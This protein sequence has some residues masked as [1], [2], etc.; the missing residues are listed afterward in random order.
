MKN[1]NFS[2]LDAM[3]LDEVNSWN[4]GL[5]F[6]ETNGWPGGL[7]CSEDEFLHIAELQT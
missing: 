3:D 6:G 4:N 5:G 1:T 2:W 7:N